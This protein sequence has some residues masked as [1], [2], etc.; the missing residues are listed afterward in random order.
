MWE[1][2]SWTQL[3]LVVEQGF[4]REGEGRGAPAGTDGAVAFDV[5]AEVAA[6]ARLVVLAPLAA[7]AVWG[8]LK[9]REYFMIYIEKYSRVQY[10]A[11]F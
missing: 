7:L 10:R 9:W 5:G 1:Q 8:E 2:K 6:T 3:Y 11:H 4:L